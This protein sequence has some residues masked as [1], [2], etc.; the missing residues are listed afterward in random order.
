[1]LPIKEEFLPS[2]DLFKEVSKN[3]SEEDSG[4]SGDKDDEL[5]KLRDVSDRQE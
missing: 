3:S 5:T 1:M 2:P 4:F